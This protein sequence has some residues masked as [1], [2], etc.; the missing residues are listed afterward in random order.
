MQPMARFAFI[1]ARVNCWHTFSLP[2]IRAPQAAPWTARRHFY[3]C[4][5][6]LHPKCR[7]WHLS[8][9]NLMQVFLACSLRLL[10]CLCEVALSSSRSA[11]SPSVVSFAYFAT[12]ELHVIVCYVN[13]YPGRRVSRLLTGEGSVVWVNRRYPTGS[14]KSCIRW[15]SS[16]SLMLSFHEK[17]EKEYSIVMEV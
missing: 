2:S 14:D 10:R 1:A 13:T 4:V 5:G 17:Q 3:C 6:L 15:Y 8:L 12:C 11:S 16:V 7:I 9:L